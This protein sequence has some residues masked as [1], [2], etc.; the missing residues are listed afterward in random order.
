MLT[1]PPHA[2]PLALARL[3]RPPQPGLVLVTPERPA[4]SHDYI[5]RSPR[6]PKEMRSRPD[7]SAIPDASDS[8]DDEESAL[9]LSAPLTGHKPVR[10]PGL[11]TSISASPP[12]SRAISHSRSPASSNLSSSSFLPRA[13]SHSASRAGF[14]PDRAIASSN[15][16][17]LFAFVLLFALVFSIPT[18][19]DFIAPRAATLPGTAPRV[20][21]AASVVHGEHG[22][23]AA[24]TALCSKLGVRVLQDLQGNAVDAA[25]AAMLCQ[26]VLSPYASGLGGGAFILV[27]FAG[28]QT[29]PPAGA[30]LD[31]RETAPH[32]VDP[33]VYLKN[34]TASRIGGAAVAVPGELRG[35]EAV[36]RRWGRVGWAQLVVPVVELA[37]EAVV[38]PMLAR[39]LLQMN[40]T[41]F[42]SPSLSAIFTRP[43]RT[44]ASIL[45]LV[46]PSPAATPAA[47][48]AND[49]SGLLP[50]LRAD[51][52]A[53]NAVE[54]LGGKEDLGNDDARRQPPPAKAAPQAKG[55]GTGFAGKGAADSAA[56]PPSKPS[57]TGPV[58][59]KEGDKLHNQALIDTLKSIATRGADHVYLDLAQ[60]LAGEVNAAGGKMT[61]KDLE[62][63][64]PVWRE[65]LLSRYEGLTVLGAPP[66][67]AGG[68]SIAM[69]LN[70][71]EGL[72]L[73][74][75]GRNGRTYLKMVEVFKYVFGARSKL[76]DPTFVPSVP[77]QVNKMLSK[78]TAITLRS[79]LNLPRAKTRDPTYYAPDGILRAA[80]TE[81]GTSHISIVDSENNAVAITSTINLPFGA[82]LASARTGFLYNNQMDSFSTSPNRPNAFGLLQ[83]KENNI[84][85]GKRP[86]SS[87]SPT[88]VMY[89]K[90]P[91]LVI[92]GSGGPRI[93]SATIQAIVNVI[94]WGDVLGDALSA[95]R[96]HHQLDPNVLWME[97]IQ[98]E[99]CELYRPLMRPS[100]ATPGGS[101]SYWP[102]VCKALKEA[103]HNVTGPSL[104]GCV[105]AVQLSRGV[106]QKDGSVAGRRLYAASDPRK[107]GLAAAF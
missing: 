12:R 75:D 17:L 60:V 102:S 34:V 54:T 19:L 90:A 51:A 68:P 11:T 15:L 101:W 4:Q 22:A 37:E 14:E 76:G 47:A 36:H 41:I 59:L 106:R 27:H 83:P 9:S 6:R 38:G 93:V 13:W 42:A 67:S 107:I 48:P 30:F 81:A 84:K 65:P 82:G 74:R 16:R 61:A 98:P 92:G 18:A 40:E 50:V 7:A 100:G 62:G 85:P 72:H 28:N 8:D 25:V 71:L 29:A 24:D 35:L 80:Q 104:D 26:G 49:T 66:P 57:S 91:Y 21:Q 88:I 2:L 20:D 73:H 105:Q 33:R 77:G 3:R 45:G 95:P 1:P 53:E 94:D 64:E 10:P 63:Y 70:I 39:R 89:K 78:R 87:M 99:K 44:A 32:Q 31:A 23:V 5:C 103:D 86:I 56:P 46:P 69:A 97:S 58:L 52:A 55:A 79:W 96:V 43:R